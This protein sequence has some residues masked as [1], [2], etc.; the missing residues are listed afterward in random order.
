MCIIIDTNTFGDFSKPSD[1][2]VVALQ[3]WLGSKQGKVIYSPIEEWEVFP[4]ELLRSLMRSDS[5]T[6]I[7][8]EEVYKEAERL[9]AD[10]ELQLKSND[11]HILAVARLSGARILYSRDRKLHTDF[12]NSSIIRGG[13]VYSSWKHRQ[14]LYDNPCA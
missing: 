8:S 12:K 11:A 2:T 7:P 9:E 13:M 1:R 6:L 10:T 5:L 4:K 14:L 3:R